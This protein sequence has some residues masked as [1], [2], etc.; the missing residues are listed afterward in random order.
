M[1]T[2][3]SAKIMNEEVRQCLEDIS[4]IYFFINRRTWAYIRN[5]VRTYEQLIQKKILGA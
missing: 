3:K 4:N 5:F 1:G 2:G